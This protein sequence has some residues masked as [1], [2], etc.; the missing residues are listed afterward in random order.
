MKTGQN[1]CCR[2]ACTYIYTSASRISF[3]SERAA[4]LCPSSTDNP[5][6]M[7]APPFPFAPAKYGWVQELDGDPGAVS[8]WY[9]NKSG[10]KLKDVANNFADLGISFFVYTNVDNC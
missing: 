2:G 10:V 4:L 6:S 8:Q 3:P 1:A 5:F 7:P 9:R